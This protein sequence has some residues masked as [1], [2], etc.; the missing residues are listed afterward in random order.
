[1]PDKPWLSIVVPMRNEA[2]IIERTLHGLQDL[3]RDGAELIVVDGDSS[4]NSHTLADPLADQVLS[5]SAG[6]ALQLQRGV[7]ASSAPLLWFLHADSRVKQVHF[8][9]LKRHRNRAWGFFPITLSGPG[10]ALRVVERGINLRSRLTGIATGDQGIFVQRSRLMEAGGV[11]SLP[12]MEDVAL[13]GRLRKIA[14]PA[15]A[16]VP[17]VT[18]SRRWEQRGVAKTVVEMWCLRAAYA[19][20]VSPQRLANY[21]QNQAPRG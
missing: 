1:M 20:G 4:D 5:T 3:R 10:L 6:R 12:L 15:L 13:T 8:S 16:R 17:L 14:R 2:A 7:E 18:S 9:E 19:V 21:Y 11:P